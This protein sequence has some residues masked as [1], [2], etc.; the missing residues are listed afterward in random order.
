MRAFAQ[1]Q[2]QPQ[3][4]VSSSLARSNMATS[5]SANCAH[6]ILHLQGAIGNQAMQWMLQTALLQKIF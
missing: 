6:P 1:Q 2:S 5:G 4:T 3:K